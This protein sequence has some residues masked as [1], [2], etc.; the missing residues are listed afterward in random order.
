[1]ITIESVWRVDMSPPVKEAERDRVNGHQAKYVSWPARHSAAVGQR[2]PLPP[3]ATRRDH[4][5]ASPGSALVPRAR[6]RD[7]ES[8]PAGPP[9]RRRPSCSRPRRARRRALGGHD[10][11]V[12]LSSRTDRSANDA[13]CRRTRD[14]LGRRSQSAL[15][16]T[17][18][19][20]AAGDHRGTTR[21]RER[22]R[23]ARPGGIC[24]R[25]SRGGGSSS[26]CMPTP[27]T[28]NGG[29]YNIDT[30]TRTSACGSIGLM[31]W[32]WN[33]AASARSRSVDRA[34]AV[35]AIAGRSG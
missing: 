1:M 11:V 2:A 12:R 28:L 8:R 30:T 24:R 18:H 23:S 3:F 27:L 9:S 21:P 32:C 20:L 17:R 25:R 34:Y 16:R 31:M 22:I 15:S 33:P 13:R 6:G 5:A 4:A 26:R 14:L 10:R 35:S 7:D 29:A 19:R